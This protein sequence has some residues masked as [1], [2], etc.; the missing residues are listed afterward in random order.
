MD[1]TPLVG[2]FNLFSAYFLFFQVGTMEPLGMPL[3]KVYI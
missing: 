1:N 2:L 3:T